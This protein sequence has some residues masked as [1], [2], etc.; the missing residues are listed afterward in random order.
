MGYSEFIDLNELKKKYWNDGTVIQ[1]NATM[2]STNSAV[3]VRLK[4][5]IVVN[6]VDPASNI[7]I[8]TSC[9]KD[10]G[11][12]GF[13]KLCRNSI[14][15]AGTE[16]TGASHAQAWDITFTD[17]MKGDSIEI[18]GRTDGVGWTR[19][20]TNTG[21]TGTPIDFRIYDN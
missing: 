3:Y 17:L 19:C 9:T 10:G 6:E 7:G 2:I 8:Y 15:I 4:H 12:V 16:V 21:L 11:G 14:D 5:F 18:W 1:S 13:W 20:D